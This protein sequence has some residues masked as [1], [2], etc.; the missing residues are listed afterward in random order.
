MTAR[1]FITVAGFMLAL[2]APSYAEDQ[3][4]KDSILVIESVEPSSGSGRERA[5]PLSEEEKQER[6]LEK[7][8]GT[9]VERDRIGRGGNDRSTHDRYGEGRFGVFQNSTQSDRNLETND[10]I[11]L[12]IKLFEFE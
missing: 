10:T 1:L 5:R 3:S 7:I 9:E 2:Y 4:Y 12:D 6:E 8:Y 11:G